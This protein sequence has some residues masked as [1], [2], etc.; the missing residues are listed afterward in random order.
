MGTNESMKKVF[1]TKLTDTNASDL[2]GIGVIRFEGA[3]I[4]KYVSYNA[5]TGVVAA[6]ADE[7]VVYHGDNAV[8]I[9]SAADVTMDVSD[10]VITA[11]VLQA[12]I[13]DTEFGWIQIKGVAVLNSALTAGLDGDLLTSVGAGDGTL[14]VVV[15][16]AINGNI[17][18]IALDASAFIVLLDCPW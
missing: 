17:S 10:G 2:E 13:A 1:I 7:V 5:G 9:D 14:D 15:T 18:A 6:V 3:K 8:V 12:V 4:Y 16:G 11:G